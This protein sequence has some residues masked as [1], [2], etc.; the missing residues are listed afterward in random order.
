[1]PPPQP[2]SFV[3]PTPTSEYAEYKDGDVFRVREIAAEPAPGDPLDALEERYAQLMGDIRGISVRL[4]AL[5]ARIA[6]K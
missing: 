5:T 3:L 6:R 2:P 4:D 1:M